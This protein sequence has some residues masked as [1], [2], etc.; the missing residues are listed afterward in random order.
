MFT[1]E[2]EWGATNNYLGHDRKWVV[3]SP[4]GM[5][6]ALNLESKSEA[7]LKAPPIH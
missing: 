3:W 2:R 6:R 4:Y 1:I 7:E 5:A